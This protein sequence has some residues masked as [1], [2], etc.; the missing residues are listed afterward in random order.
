MLADVRV[1]T[2]AEPEVAVPAAVRGR[3][4]W[5]DAASRFMRNKAAVTSVILLL[6]V[7]L[8]AIVG[9]RFEA[10][11]IEIDPAVPRY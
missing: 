7:V 2:T 1:E 6:L 3:S 11:S 5:K 8:F 4:L 9:P 10:W